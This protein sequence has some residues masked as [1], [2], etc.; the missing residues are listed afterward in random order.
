MEHVEEIG[1]IFK[2]DPLF[3]YIINLPYGL[4][5]KVVERRKKRLEKDPIGG[6]LH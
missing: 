2:S 3:D 6:L 1:A 5:V 4:F